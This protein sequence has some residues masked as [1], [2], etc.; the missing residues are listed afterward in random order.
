[1]D[2]VDD[3]DICLGEIVECTVANNQVVPSHRSSIGSFAI[4]VGGGVIP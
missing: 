1:M 4:V 2:G 3:V